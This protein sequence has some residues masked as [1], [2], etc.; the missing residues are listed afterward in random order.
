[1]IQE[2]FQSH[3]QRI[4]SFAGA[5]HTFYDHQRSF[6]RRLHQGFLK[7]ILPCV[8]GADAVRGLFSVIQL[9]YNSIFHPA[10]LG[11]LRGLIRPQDHKLILFQFRN[12]ILSVFF[13]NIHLIRRDSLFL[14]ILK[15][16]FRHID[17]ASA[18]Y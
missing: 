5:R 15:N 18:V 12:L 7:K 16:L 14:K 4:K 2:F 13:E 11:F 17:F 1:M 3:C 6:I 9:L 8:S 10:Q